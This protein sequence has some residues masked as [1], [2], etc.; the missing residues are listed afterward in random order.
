VSETIVQ[1][2][3]MSVVACGRDPGGNVCLTAELLGAGARDEER[4]E[5]KIETCVQFLTSM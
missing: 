2:S 1:C 3:A 5:Y 4:K